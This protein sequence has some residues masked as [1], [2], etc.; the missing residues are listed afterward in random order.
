MLFTVH[1]PV[2]I[3][4]SCHVCAPSPFHVPYIMLYTAIQNGATHIVR[5]FRGVQKIPQQTNLRDGNKIFHGLHLV[6]SSR[7]MT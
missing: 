2:P 5:G 1:D 4:L 3:R 7:C 6:L